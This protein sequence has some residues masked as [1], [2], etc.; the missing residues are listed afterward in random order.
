MIIAK[1][2]IT[3]N[4]SLLSGTDLPLKESLEILLES[5]DNCGIKHVLVY[6]R[7]DAEVTMKPG[8]DEWLEEVNN[9]YCFLLLYGHDLI[10]MLLPIGNGRAA[11]RV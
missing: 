2:I 1:V 6:K 10:I 3:A 5:S 9:Y 4:K 11:Y 8:R 7:T